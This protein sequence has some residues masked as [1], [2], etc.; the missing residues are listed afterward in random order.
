[1]TPRKGASNCR[2]S[3]PVSARHTLRNQTFEAVFQPLAGGRML[4]LRHADH[5]DLIVSL[6]DASFPPAQ[7]PKAGAFPLFPFHNRVRNAAFRLDER[8]IQLSAN[9]ANGLDTMHGPAHQR[10]WHVTDKGTSFIAMELVFAPDHDWPY[11]FTARQRFEL[12]ED[13][14]IV[15]LELTNSGSM[16]MPGGLGWHPYFQPTYDGQVFT[17]AKTQWQENQE[18][19]RPEAFEPPHSIESCA[20]QFGITEHFANWSNATARIGIGTTIALSATIGLSHLTLLRQKDY[21][22]IEPTSH[23]AGAFAT[24]P[25]PP[26]ETGLCILSPGQTITGTVTLQVNRQDTSNKP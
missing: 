6:R 22:C 26:A 20:L 1:M 9:A 11:H 5:G 21:L 15:A 2:F 12:Y 23:V 17:D 8:K 3:D 16:N 18:T 14:L 13:Q 10:P 19:N 4:S 25:E 7:W 24:L